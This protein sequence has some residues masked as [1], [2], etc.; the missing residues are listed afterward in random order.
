VVQTTGENEKER[1]EDGRGGPRRPWTECL[2]LQAG[3]E[4][5]EGRK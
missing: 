1:R 3:S 4:V 5:L 2:Y